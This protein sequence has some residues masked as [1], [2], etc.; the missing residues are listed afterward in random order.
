[1]RQFA[2]SNIIG[3]NTKTEEGGR[4][5]DERVSRES[6]YLTVINVQ[7]SQRCSDSKVDCCLLCLN[8]N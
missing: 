3:K 6:H 5:P 7:A 1:M 4:A 2:N 8:Y